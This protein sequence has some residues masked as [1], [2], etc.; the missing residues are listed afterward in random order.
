MASSSLLSTAPN[1]HR[2]RLARAY[3]FPWV[4]PLGTFFLAY[5]SVYIGITPWLAWGWFAGTVVCSVIED[6]AV[7]QSRLMRLYYMLTKSVLPQK[8]PDELMQE[9]VVYT[10]YSPPPLVAY[11]SHIWK[12]SLVVIIL[13]WIYTLTQSFIE[14]SISPIPQTI[15]TMLLLIFTILPY[16]RMIIAPMGYATRSGKLAVW[17]CLAVVG[18]LFA[19]LSL[20]HLTDNLVIIF[21]SA[22]IIALIYTSIYVSQRLWAGEHILNGVIRDVGMDFLSWTDTEPK[23]GSVPALIGKRLQHDRVFILLPTPDHK[24]LTISSEYGDYQSVI[25][26]KI[27]VETSLTGRAFREKAPVVWNEIKE[28]PYYHS[29]CLDDDTRAEIAVPIIHRQVVYGILDVQSKQKGV[30]GPGDVSSLQTITHIL[31]AAIASEQQERLFNQTVQLWEELVAATNTTYVSEEDVFELFASFL[32]DTFKADLVIYFPLSLTGCAVSPPYTRGKFFHPEYLKPPLNDANSF[33]IQQIARWQPYYEEEITDISLVAQPAHATIPRFVI[34]EKI[35]SSCF[36]PVGMQQER[37]GALFL[38]FRNPQPFNTLFKFII[39][40]LTQSLA[41]VTAQIRYRDILFKSF[42]RPEL[43]LHQ[44]IGR[45][46]LKEGVLPRANSLRR[47]CGTDCCSSL[48]ECVLSEVFHDM[49][50]FLQELHLAESSIPPDFWHEGLEEQ[51]H[52]YSSVRPK[53]RS[54][55]RPYLHW[56]VEAKIE[57]E[58]PWVKLALYR[59]VTEAVNN[60]ILHGD[61]SEITV[62]IHRHPHHIEVNITNNGLPLPDDAYKHKSNHGIFM[63][64][65][66][67]QHRLGATTSIKRVLAESGTA[68]TISVPALPTSSIDY[69]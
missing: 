40:S 58:S 67:L 34:R 62:T 48:N 51:L 59:V 63:L 39:L 45:R 11:K 33:L 2:R 8:S 42:G 22:G 13:T 44:I 47:R 17:T 65:E 36:I 57:R 52:N 35:K 30:Y 25:N 38:N 60:A 43:G 19:P 54:G 37:L 24:E 10:S 68:V 53:Q 14:T 15:L 66:E 21:L 9:T 4:Q 41:K 32:Q 16:G 49:E 29:I 27:P 12:A 1:L 20:H 3:F 26:Q 18:V 23:L 50:D 6:L 55:R 46:G 69:R 64:L 5:Y 31:G 61:A 28:C 7:P 56:H